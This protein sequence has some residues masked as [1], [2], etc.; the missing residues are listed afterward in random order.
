MVAV[1]AAVVA[2]VAV[3]NKAEV[4]LPVQ[5]WRRQNAGFFAEARVCFLGALVYR[6]KMGYI[7]SRCHGRVL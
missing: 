4:L 5:C 6:K 7:I 1:V 3:E 2:V